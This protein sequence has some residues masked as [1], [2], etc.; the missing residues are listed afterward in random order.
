MFGYCGLVVEI[1]PLNCPKLNCCCPSNV[2]QERFASYFFGVAHTYVQLEVY[3]GE[4]PVEL[5]AVP[6]EYQI[7]ILYNPE[8]KENN[9]VATFWS[10]FCRPRQEMCFCSRAVENLDPCAILEPAPPKRGTQFANTPK[11]GPN[12]GWVKPTGAKW[13][14]F[15]LI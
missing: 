4:L 7:T 14:W 9:S 5:P 10:R 8:K 12:S 11:W 3:S 1:Q 2:N 15:V 13:I 6:S